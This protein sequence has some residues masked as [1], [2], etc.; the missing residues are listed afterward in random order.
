MQ[1]ARWRVYSIRQL[2]WV[3]W[4]NEGVVHVQVD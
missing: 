1:A 2:E 3:V 4:G